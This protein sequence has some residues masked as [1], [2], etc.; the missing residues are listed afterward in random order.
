M[1]NTRP[2][3]INMKERINAW[4]FGKLWYLE[5]YDDKFQE[6]V[7]MAEM[8]DYENYLKQK[9][10]TNEARKNAPLEFL[11][12]YAEPF[13][14]KEQEQHLFRQYNFVKYKYKQL[15]ESTELKTRDT[16][17]AKIIHK[18]DSYYDKMNDAKQK[19][20]C[21][22]AR[23]VMNLAKK[24]Q[25][26]NLDA[27]LSEGYTGLTMAVDYFD[28][29]K[30][31]K[32]ITYC[33]LVIKDYIRKYKYKENKHSAFTN[34]EDLMDWELA[35]SHETT[36]EIVSDNECKRMINEKLLCATARERQI[37]SYYYGLNGGRQLTLN[38]IGKK[39]KISKERVRQ[40]KFVGIR[41]MQRNRIPYYETGR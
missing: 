10:K 7:I 31:V 3:F 13:L 17:L 20:V 14:S 23:L 19:L 2:K 29:R 8:P 33:Y 12:M 40:I 6:K 15:V 34:Y 22:N 16:S 35:D 30:G 21:A 18:L 9:A 4:Q 27:V 24:S 26:P 5:S 41:R 37:I 28:F 25:I 36:E 32:F 1:I 39:L 38:E 11:F